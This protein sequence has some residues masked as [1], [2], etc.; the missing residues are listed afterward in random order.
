V[1]GTLYIRKD[2]LHFEP[3]QD[4]I[5]NA[6]FNKDNDY[7]LKVEDYATTIEYFDILELN[8]LPLI[9]E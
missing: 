2:S 4:S 8:K 1:F 5:E 6:N 9:N 7:G 3:D